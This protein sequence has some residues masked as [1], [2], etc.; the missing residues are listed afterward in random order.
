MGSSCV[1]TPQI[2]TNAFY[3]PS[4]AFKSIQKR[5]KEARLSASEVRRDFIA[6]LWQRYK[7]DYTNYEIKK[8]GSNCFDEKRKDTSLYAIRA[9]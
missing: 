6:Y 2:S 8:F 3:S 1:S 7:N 9:N 5:I 4:P